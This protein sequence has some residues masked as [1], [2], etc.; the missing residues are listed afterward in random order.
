VKCEECGW[1]L[2][3]SQTECSN[4]GESVNVNI[5]KD[6]KENIH[7]TSENEEKEENS[8]KNK[9]NTKLIAVCVDKNYRTEIEEGE[10]EFYCE[11]CQEWH[12][13]D[14]DMYVI[15]RVPEETESKIEEEKEVETQIESKKEEEDSVLRLVLKG[16]ES[17]FI[18][19]PK[20]GGII[21][22]SGDYGSKFFN[23]RYLL[24]ISREHFGIKFED[25]EWMIYHLGKNDTEVNG[26]NLKHG[27]FKI[28]R[29]NDKLR[30]AKT[31]SFEVRIKS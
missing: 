20:K 27:T 24:T 16:N 10:V 15:E 28:I 22:R 12:R 23:D 8:S 3:E 25:E 30:L 31:I 21:G 18:E 14:D 26:E 17:E 4:C 6:E 2:E 7:E 19:I 9:S 5:K 13:I 11:E 1:E 29:N